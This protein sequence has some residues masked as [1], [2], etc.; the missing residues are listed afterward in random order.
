MFKDM[1][2][3]NIRAD[4]LFL[5]ADGILADDELYAERYS[6]ER[7]NVRIGCFRTILPTF[8]TTLSICTSWNH[9]AFAILLL[10]NN[11]R[12]QKVQIISLF[13]E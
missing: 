6:I 5:N 7:T 13:K 8:D 11:S 12:K 4:D 1:V 2:K 9:L 10:K 3:Y